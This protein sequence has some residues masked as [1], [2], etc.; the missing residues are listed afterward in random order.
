MVAAEY[1][2]GMDSETIMRTHHAGMKV[3]EVPI[4]MNYGG[5]KTS[6]HNRWGMVL[7]LYSAS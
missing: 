2:M 6:T 1:E 4:D 7:M 3:V 5:V